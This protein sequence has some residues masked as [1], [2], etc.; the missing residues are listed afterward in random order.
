MRNILAIYALT[1][2]VLTPTAGGAQGSLRDSCSDLAA[3]ISSLAN[4]V[5]E[6]NKKLQGIRWDSATP[7]GVKEIDINSDL[8]RALQNAGS[9]QTALMNAMQSYQ[10]AVEAVVYRL[11]RC[12]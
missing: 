1:A 7:L 4:Q 9:Q 8:Q 6:F 11:Q 3:G 12:A 2:L 5:A 10:T